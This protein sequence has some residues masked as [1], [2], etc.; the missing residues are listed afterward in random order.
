MMFNMVISVMISMIVDT[1]RIRVNTLMT[2]PNTRR[3]YVTK[4]GHSGPGYSKVEG[5]ITLIVAK[6]YSKLHP[7]H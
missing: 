7:K 4:M 6:I 3:M 5:I 2:P 1:I